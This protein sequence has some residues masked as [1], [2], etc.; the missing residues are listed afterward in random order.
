MPTATPGSTFLTLFRVV[1]TMDARSAM[2][3]VGMRR[4]RRA[5]R[6]SFPN[7]ESARQT[8]IGGVSTEWLLPAATSIKAV[9]I[10]YNAYEY[11]PKVDGLWNLS[12]LSFPS[13]V[14]LG[15]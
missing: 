6:I 15:L 12:L 1:R 7:F 13:T 10:Q 5:S 14:P 3:A 11:E 4:L 2:I 9:S 8:G